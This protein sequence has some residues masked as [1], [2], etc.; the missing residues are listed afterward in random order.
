MGWAEDELGR[1]CGLLGLLLSDHGPKARM[2]GRVW[3]GPYVSEFGLRVLEL[4]S[5]PVG[6]QLFGAR[7][8]GSNPTQPGYNPVHWPVN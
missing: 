5:L 6:L 1:L 8:W 2:L 7:V 3:N 4:R